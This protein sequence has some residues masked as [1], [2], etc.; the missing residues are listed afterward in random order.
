MATIDHQSSH[1]ITTEGAQGLWSSIHTGVGLEKERHASAMQDQPES[2]HGTS[3][4]I[5][6]GWSYNKSGAAYP[7]RA[8]VV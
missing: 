7:A 6:E 3:Y 5:S 2:D 1:S 8:R 4:H